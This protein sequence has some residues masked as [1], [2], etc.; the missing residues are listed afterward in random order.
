MY[1]SSKAIAEDKKSPP[2]PPNSTG[3]LIPNNP[4]WTKKRR[5]HAYLLRNKVKRIISLIN[6]VFQLPSKLLY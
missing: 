5:K 4:K 2:I 3:V 1:C 6:L